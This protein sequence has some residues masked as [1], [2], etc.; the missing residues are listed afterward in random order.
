MC[1]LP[2][3]LEVGGKGTRAPG[4][5]TTEYQQF[6]T[7]SPD[8]QLLIWDTRFR[9]DAKEMGTVVYFY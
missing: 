3:L 5:D 2:P 8:G 9:R 4:P 6:I 1:W 7:T